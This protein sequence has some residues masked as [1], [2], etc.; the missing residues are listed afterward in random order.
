VFATESIACSGSQSRHQSSTAGVGQIIEHVA[1]S[2]DPPAS[3]QARSRRHAACPEPQPGWG[4]RLRHRQPVCNTNKIPSSA[5]RSS[6][7]GRPPGPLARAA[8][9]GINGSRSS[10]SRSTSS[11][12]HF[13]PPSEDDHRHPRPRLKA[14]NSCFLS[15][16]GV[17]SIQAS[18]RLEWDSKPCRSRPE[19]VHRGHAGSTRCGTSCMAPP[20]GE[21]ADRIADAALRGLLADTGRA[22]AGPPG[23]PAQEE[24]QAPWNT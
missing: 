8:G 1:V 21:Q 5:A 7:C 14:G 15:S 11:R 2:T 23:N 10:W 4:G 22:E 9:P 19:I 3:S 16:I 18:W 13:V 6:I 12:S 20:T 17:D 24:G